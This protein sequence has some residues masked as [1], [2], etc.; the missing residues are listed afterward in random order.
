MMQYHFDTSL[1]RITQQISKA[2][3]KTFEKKA[4]D[5][6]HNLRAEE[7]TLISLLHHQGDL[8]QQDIAEKLF[9][10]KVAI[11]RMVFKMERLKTVS[12]KASRKDKRAKVVTLTPTGR[13]LYLTMEPIAQETITGVLIGLNTEKIDQLFEGLNHMK[14]RLGL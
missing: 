1:G 4:R 12:R 2:L 11:S 3:G 9:M 13:D 8:T 10:D 14:G 6:G 7:W 5:A